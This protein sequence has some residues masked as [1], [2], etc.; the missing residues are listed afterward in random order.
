MAAPSRCGV[1]RLDETAAGLEAAGV[2]AMRLEMLLDIV[3][4]RRK[5]FVEAS[6]NAISSEVDRMYGRVHPDEGLGGLRFFLK[7]HTSGSLE[8]AGRFL[9]EEDVPPQAYYSE[10][11]LDTLGICVFLALARQTAGHRTT[12]ALDDVFTAVDAAHLD[13]MLRMLQDESGAFL[14]IIATTHYAAWRDHF[15]RHPTPQVQ[16]IELEPWHARDGIR[17]ASGA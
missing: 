9:H 1:A 11:H 7:A 10:S 12:V 5:G 4:G 17:L 8:Y 15:R 3:S 2:A 14:R 16:L 6:L 13:R